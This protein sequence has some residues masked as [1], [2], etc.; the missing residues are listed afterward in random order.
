MK[1]TKFQS[2]VVFAEMR[3]GSNFLEANLNAFEGINCHGEAFNPHFM[4]YPN[5]DP[6]LGIDLKTRDADPK[7]LLAAI[8][9]N[10]ARLSGFRYFHDHDPRVFDAIVD[11]PTCAKV[12]LT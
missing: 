10:T 12:I 6:I 3:T 11:D 8:R 2:F 5:S 7:V 9:N 4:G 1:S